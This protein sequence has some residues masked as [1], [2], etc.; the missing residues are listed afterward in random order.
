MALRWRVAAAA[1]ATATATAP[2]HAAL[3]PLPGMT[4]VLLRRPMATDAPANGE[5]KADGATLAAEAEKE[6]DKIPALSPEEVRKVARKAGDDGETVDVTRT[7]LPHGVRRCD[8]S[9]IG[10]RLVAVLAGTGRLC[11]PVE[12]FED[13]VFDEALAS[14]NF[15]R[16]QDVYS[17]Q[18]RERQQLVLGLHKL[19]E[20]DSV[21]LQ[22]TP[23]HRAGAP[24]RRS[25]PATKP[26]ALAR[27]VAWRLACSVRAPVG[28]AGR[29]PHPPVRERARAVCG[30]RRRGAGRPEGARRRAGPQARPGRRGDP[31][32]EGASRRYAV[33][34]YASTASAERGSRFPLAAAPR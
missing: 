30:P 28:A 3:R 10:S 7:W 12:D 20:N 16:S 19:L 32:P 23:P 21:M 4:A 33:T 8:G 14:G 9:S 26:T 5:E 25:R 18:Q 6:A 31:A 29:R 34:A 27:P 11:P 15:F 2:R 1:A 22:C 17:D 24:A 13:P